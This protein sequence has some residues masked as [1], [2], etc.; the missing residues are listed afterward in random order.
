VA[1]RVTAGSP[2]T[3]RLRAWLGSIDAST[4]WVRVISI[5]ALTRIIATAGFVWAA[6]IQG[7]TP[8]SATGHPGY[9]EFIDTWDDEWYRRI[10]QHGIGHDPGYP[11]HLPTFPNGAVQQNAWAFMPGFPLLVRLFTILTG[12][13]VSWQVLAPTISLILSFG[14]ALMMFKVFRLKLDDST[15]LW[16]VTLFGFWCASPV[17]QTGYA[18]SLGLLLLACGLYF[19]MQHRYLAALPWLVGLSITRPG[20]VSFAAMLAGMWIVRWFKHRRGT[21]EFDPKE[22]WGLAGLTVASGFLGLLWPI[23]AWIFTHRADAYTVTELAWRVVDPHA[24]LVLFEGWVHLGQRWWGDFWA[25]MFVLLVMGVSAWV[26]FTKPMRQLGNEL[27]LWVAAYLLYLF[28]VFNAQSSTF[29]ILMPAFPLIAGV[30]IYSRDWRRWQKIFLLI[31]MAAS[32]V[33]WLRICWVF[34]SPDF[35]PP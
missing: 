6:S 18:E 21:D 11:T 22:R 30:A 1:E 12:G 19:L 20:M 25:P 3:G 27:R 33:V 16:A 10:F 31:L 29:R 28:L 17:L 35:T 4:W 2:A 9:F 34:A 13:L 23:I 5:W 15:S 7:P 24:H 14:L 32:Q 8:W 26:L